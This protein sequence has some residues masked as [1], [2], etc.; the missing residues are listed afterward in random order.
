MKVFLLHRDRDLDVKPE[1]RDAIFGAMVS[2]NLYAI[3]N[4]K[5][6]L[7]RQWKSSSSPDSTASDDVLAQ[8][9]ELDTLWNAMAAGDE[10][11]FE[12]AKRGVLS[13]LSDPEEIVYRQQ[14]L[15]DCL[16]H[17]A[18]VRQIYD[19]AIEALA[20]EREVGGLWS[21][22][23]PGYILH[24]SVRLLKLYVDILKRLRQIADERS[25]GF[26]SEG[27]RRFFAMLWEELADEYFEGIEQHLREL[28]LKR[29]VLESAELAK[30]IRATVTSSTD[31]QSTGRGGRTASRPSEIRS[32][33]N[34]ASSFI[35]ETRPA[36]GRWRR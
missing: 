2:G 28:E 33:R 4:A 3:A 29:G 21:G 22:A 30:G 13:S 35:P 24:R 5:R 32:G 14:V 12:I 8:D 16:E 6:N 31:P 1:L 34:T 15:A 25:Q 17:P 26:G 9:L 20:S 11:V 36:T 18:T 10:F 19:L 7:K 27:F 23:G